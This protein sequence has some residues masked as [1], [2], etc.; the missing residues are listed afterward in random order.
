[1]AEETHLGSGTPQPQE[2]HSASLLR[3]LK[4]AQ[5]S[6]DL[7]DFRQKLREEYQT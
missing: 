1:M 6:K 4:I 2:K 3:L 5:E 7:E